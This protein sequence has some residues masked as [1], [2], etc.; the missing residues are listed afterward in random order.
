MIKT[1]SVAF[2]GE[3]DKNAQDQT[4][5]DIPFFK[6]ELRQKNSGLPFS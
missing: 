3:G 2:S 6:S 1:R 5:G 4:T